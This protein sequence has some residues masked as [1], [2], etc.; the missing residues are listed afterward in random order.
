[1][2]PY[3]ISHNYQ[4]FHNLL[5]YHI[6]MKSPYHE[7][8]LQSTCH[9]SYRIKPYH[10]ILQTIKHVIRHIITLSKQFFIVI[11]SSEIPA[12]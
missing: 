5:P 1:M 3:I 8:Y 6:R 7:S 4:L 10:I 11:L 12:S 9:L 2:V